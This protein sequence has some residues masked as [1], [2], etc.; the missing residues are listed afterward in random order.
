MPLLTVL[1]LF[2]WTLLSLAGV[3]LIPVVVALR[4]DGIAAAQT[5]AVPAVLLCILSSLL[6]MAFRGHNELQRRR[7][8]LLLLVCAWLLIPAAAALPLYLA[9]FPGNFLHAYFEAVSGFTTTGATIFDDLGQLPKSIILW[10]AMLQWLGG[11]TTLLAL[12][13]LLGSLSGT[14]LMDRQLRLIGRPAQDGAENLFEV[15]QSVAPLYLALTVVCFLLLVVFGTPSFEALCLAL[16]AISTGGFA[17]R[18]Q[19]L[20]AYV[21]PAAQLVLALFMILG[22]VSFVWVRA[23]FQMRW[24]IIRETREPFWI[25][26]LT[27]AAALVAIVVLS[28]VE[29]AYGPGGAFRLVASGIASA[30]SLISTTG[31]VIT[32]PARFPLPVILLATVCIVGGGRFS[33][34]GG[35]KVFRVFLMLRQVSREL[36]QLIYPHGVRAARFGDEARESELLKATWITFAAFIITLGTIM[37]LVAYSGVPVAGA[38]LAAAG[39]LS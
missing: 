32:D 17:P 31:F 15:M 11:L 35:L 21:P 27:G 29:P 8:N 28:A 23:I 4:L 6:I 10:R 26:W 19:P 16:S 24:P 1:Y 39:A 7:Q 18:S 20:A 37:A 2:G 9:G 25:I 38:L 5:F 30:A 14:D 13:A 36:R 34:A 3:M 33:T 22:A 12:L